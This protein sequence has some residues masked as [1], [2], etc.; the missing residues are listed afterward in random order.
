MIC[1]LTHGDEEAP[2]QQFRPLKIPDGARECE[3]TLA[4]LMNRQAEGWCP[5]ETYDA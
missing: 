3:R 4:D 5:L 2:H 1:A